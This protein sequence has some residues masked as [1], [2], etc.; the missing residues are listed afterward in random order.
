MVPELRSILSAC[1]LWVT[2]DRD[3]SLILR[4]HARLPY[5]SENVLFRKLFISE[6]GEW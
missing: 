1:Q 2:S 6:K 5:A 3:D 4:L